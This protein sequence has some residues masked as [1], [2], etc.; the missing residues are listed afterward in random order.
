MDKHEK[1]RTQIKQQPISGCV[2]GRGKTKTQN[3]ETNKQ[4]MKKKSFTHTQ[5]G[6][7]QFNGNLST[8]I[9]QNSHKMVKFMSME[10]GS[11]TPLSA[12]HWYTPAWWRST[13]SSISV[14]LSDKCV[15]PEK[16]SCTQKL[17]QNKQTKQNKIH[18]KFKSL[19]IHLSMRWERCSTVE[20]TL[21]TFQHRN[22]SQ[23]EFTWICGDCV[24]TRV[25]VVCPKLSYR[26]QW[27][28]QLWPMQN[29]FQVNCFRNYL[30]PHINFSLRILRIGM[31]HRNECAFRFLH[32]STFY[33]VQNVMKKVQTP[34]K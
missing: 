6:I 28:L 23:W 29:R 25:W 22:I 10:T 21:V 9:E 33:G 1:K 26:F 16:I 20:S 32:E 19:N 11:R 30:E 13:R 24:C 14:E 18:V 34:L 15:D 4:S 7:W 31:T 8:V 3:Q 5:I 12:A 2:H 27:F 17:E